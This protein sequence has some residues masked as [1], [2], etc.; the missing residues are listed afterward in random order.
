M[1]E[2]ARTKGEDDHLLLKSRRKPRR[3]CEFKVPL[4]WVLTSI[5]LTHKKNNDNLLRDQILMD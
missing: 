3:K 2:E 4:I 5:K 1:R